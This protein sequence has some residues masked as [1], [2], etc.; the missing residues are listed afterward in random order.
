MFITIYGVGFL[1]EMK[2]AVDQLGEDDLKAK[3][4]KKEERKKA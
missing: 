2:R 4:A 1:A 3:A